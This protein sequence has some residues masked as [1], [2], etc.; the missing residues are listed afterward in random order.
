MNKY[1]IVVKTRI[2]NRWM[3][4]SKYE[5][6]SSGKPLEHTSNLIGRIPLYDYDMSVYNENNIKVRSQIRT[7]KNK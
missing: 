4:L 3:D 1:E 6:N 2:F 7:I 5:C